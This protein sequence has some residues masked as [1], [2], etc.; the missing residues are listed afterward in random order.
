[1]KG[2]LVVELDLLGGEGLR[3]LSDRG[4]VGI[5]LAHGC[6][7]TLHERDAV[8]QA[9]EVA[10]RLRKG[11]ALRLHGVGDGQHARA[12]TCGER[13][14]NARE[15]FAAAHAEHAAHT[16]LR[17]AVTAVGD[18][19]VK[20]RKAVSHGAAGALG[21]HAQRAF[22][23]RNALFGEDAAHVAHDVLGR[24]VAQIELQTAREHGDG[25]LLRVRRREDELHVFGRLLKRLEHGVEGRRAQHVDFVDHVNLEAALRGRVHRALKERGH[26]LD[27]TIARRIHL[28]VVGEASLVDRA[29]G[30]ADSAGMSRHVAVAVRPLAVEGLGE[31]AGDRRLAD[32]AGS[33]EEIGVMKAL[34]RESARE[35]GHDVLLAD[36]RVE[37]MRPP[38]SGEHLIAAHPVSLVLSECARTFILAAQRPA[39][40]RSASPES[41]QMRQSGSTSAPSPS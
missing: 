1:M 13:P 32:A 7:H 15:R 28:D 18:G 38:L 25:H 21:E 4:A 31:D 8:Q 39:A 34:F 20:K 24:H 36:D 35:R 9:R 11:K 37:V 6:G 22:L 33:R 5:V 30:G 19:L 2:D 17:H 14:E 10:E 27:R 3:E 16:F 26:V 40:L 12:V 41:L 23:E 29:A